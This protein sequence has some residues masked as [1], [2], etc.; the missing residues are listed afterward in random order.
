MKINI[1]QPSG[2]VDIKSILAS[3]FPFIF[4]TGGRAT[5]KTYTSLKYAVESDTKFIYMR[6]TQS[7]SDLINRP[8]FS[9]FK[10]YC[11]DTGTNIVTEPITKYNSA[12][13]YGEMAANSDKM[14]PSG[15]PIGYTAA[16]S[17]IANMRG[18][19]ASDVQILIYDEFI[20]E[21]HERPLKNEALAFFNAYESINRNR[22]LKGGL[23]LQA[24]CLA[25][26]MSIDNDIYRHLK[27]VDVV[28]NMKKKGHEYWADK[29][30]GILIIHLHRSPISSK[31][32]TTA[33]YKLTEGSNFYDMA[34][35][36][37]FAFE[38]RGNIKPQ[39]LKEYIPKVRV[40]DLCIYLHKSDGRVYACKHTTGTPK[41]EFGTGEIE[42]ERF[43]KMFYFLWS[44]YMSGLIWF[45]TYDSE[46]DFRIAF[47]K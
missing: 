33:L 27:L 43:R 30:R 45:D 23:P 10:S 17:T 15:A 40:G 25:N 9:P 24:L 14:K 36:N 4:I 44:D 46:L 2:Y 42:K 7:Q 11:M 1:Y 39:P 28:D 6:R 34:I 21:K 37:N 16:L 26:A 5:G 29:K 3:G 41:F 12:F 22:E 32:G 8:E 35:S 31:K 19:D 18:F 47:G 20:K 38:E 13:Y